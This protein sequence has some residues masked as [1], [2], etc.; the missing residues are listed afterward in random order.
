MGQIGESQLVSQQQVLL[1][2]EP[3]DLDLQRNGKLYK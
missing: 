3:S 1:N 2:S